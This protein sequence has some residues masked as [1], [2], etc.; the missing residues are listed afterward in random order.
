ML[1][2]LFGSH[3]TLNS[4]STNVKHADR[5]AAT[6]TIRKEKEYDIYLYFL[7]GTPVEEIMERTL[8]E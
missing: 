4:T 6:D 2:L 7:T 3:K 5:P 1:R 8:I